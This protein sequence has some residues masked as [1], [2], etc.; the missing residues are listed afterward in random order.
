MDQDRGVL[1]EG[2]YG[3]GEHCVEDRKVCP[4][5]GAVLSN[6]PPVSTNM[7]CLD[8]LSIVL[9]VVPEGQEDF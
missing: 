1:R 5:G 3:F 7:G 9:Q 8:P 6:S 2:K 4:E